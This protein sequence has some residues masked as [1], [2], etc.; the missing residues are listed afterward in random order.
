LSEVITNDDVLALANGINV[1]A[2]LTG[3]VKRSPMKI[4]RLIRAYL[5]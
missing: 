1:A 2:T 5:R 4:I 3:L